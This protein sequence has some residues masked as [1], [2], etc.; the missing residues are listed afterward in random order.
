MSDPDVIDL[1]SGLV[2]ILFSTPGCGV[3]ESLKLKLPGWSEQLGYRARFV[4]LDLERFPEACSRFQVLSVPT[5]VVRLDGQE[6]SRQLR[7]IN[8]SLLEEH[9]ERP[10]AFWSEL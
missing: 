8:L 7:H 9:I 6:L 1:V 4:W 2:F 5:L 3:C 10:L